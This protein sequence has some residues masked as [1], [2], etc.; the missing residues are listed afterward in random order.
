[1]R[2]T[3]GLGIDHELNLALRPA[4]HSLAAM[5]AASAEAEL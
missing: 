2:K 4:L 5:L 1:M 3:V